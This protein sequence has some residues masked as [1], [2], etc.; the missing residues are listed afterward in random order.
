MPERV[1]VVAFRGHGFRRSAVS[2]LWGCVYCGRTTSAFSDALVPRC[3]HFA[4]L[5][6]LPSE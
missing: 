2:E 3:K 6:G 1:Y 5:P 4:P